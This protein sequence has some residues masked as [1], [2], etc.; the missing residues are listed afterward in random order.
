MDSIGGMLNPIGKMP[1]THYKNTFF[2]GFYW[3]ELMVYN[4]I[5]KGNHW[6]ICDGFY[7][8]SIV[9]FN[10]RFLY[11]KAAIWGLPFY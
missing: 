5:L 9:I 11:L 6:D 1:I 4:G 8:A 3:K 7:W 2:Y 10:Q